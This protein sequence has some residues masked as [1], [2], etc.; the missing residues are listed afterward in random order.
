MLEVDGLVVRYGPVE[1]LKGV[2]IRVGEGEAVTIV[3]SNGAGKTTLLRAVA[4]LLRPTAGRVRYR[5]ED[6]TGR[7]T[8]VLVRRGLVLV[9]EGRAIL[10]RLSVGE[11]LQLGA[12]ARG[13]P[14][15]ETIELCLHH[16]PILRE[17]WRFQAGLL[18]GG[19]QQMV[20]VARAL[21]A[22]P[23]L[24]CLD[25]PS[26][27]L[28]P[29]AVE[30]I[31]SVLAQLRERLTVLLVEQN[32]AMALRLADRGYVLETGRVVLQGSSDTLLQHR[33]VREAYLGAAVAN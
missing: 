24:L 3:G 32:A 5:G 15:P 12:Y 1:A 7:G 27:G 28:A 14:R 10:Q 9:P 11:N 29:L 33:R 22:E 16:F 25:E 31:F 17:R 26:L 19:E 30:A 21:C 8:P 2:E 20:A 13:R 4:G 6:V 23:T 18:S